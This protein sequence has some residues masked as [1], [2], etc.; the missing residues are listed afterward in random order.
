MRILLLTQWFEPEPT[1]K[2]MVFAREL[3]ARG[4]SVQVL[5]GFPNYPGGR[6]YPGYKVRPWLREQREGV[7]IVRVALY[8][9]HDRNALGRAANYLSFAASAAFLGAFLVAKPDVVYVYH[10][11]A[12]VGLAALAISLFRGA[13]FVLDIQDLWPDS[14]ASSGMLA[15]PAAI[16]LLASWCRLLYR[17]AAKIVVLSD[18]FRGRLIERGVPPSKIE[19]IR[20][21]C[22]EASMRQ[23]PA[24]EPEL[25]AGFNVVF[26]GAMG[27]MQGLD[28]VLDASKICAAD[29][30]EA[31]FVFVGGGIERDRL[32]RRAHAEGLA[33]VLFLPRRP[34]ER[35]GALFAQ[36]DVLL[37][38]LKDDPLFRITIP[39]KMQAYM[40]AGKTILMAVAGEAA[41][42]VAEAEAGVTCE[43]DN[44][45]QIA[46][47]VASLARMPKE[48]LARL[49]ANGARYYADNMSLAIGAAR[50]DRIFR[51]VAAVSGTPAGPYAAFGKRLFDL[52]A[53]T[54]AAVL[55]SP[56]LALA[57]GSIKASSSGPVLFRQ[58][59]IG[60]G[61]RPF[62]LLKFRTMTHRHRVPDRQTFW[63]DPE[64]TSVGKWLRRFKLDEL[65]QLLNVIRGEMS[66]VGPRPC[67]PDLLNTID[68]AGR[69]RF[70]VRPGL[71][72]LA[73][74][75][76]NVYIS[77]E[78]RWR[79]DADY[80]RR[81][82]FSLDLRILIR[83]VAVVL[84]GE[85]RFAR[86]TG[87]PREPE[88][89]G[90]K[91]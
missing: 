87:P 48:E 72:G 19:V 70:L 60:L 20:N 83:T 13:P 88:A 67:L 75:N 1:F 46:A 40:V 65:P 63:D 34:P 21:W 37:V 26:A 16:S 76:G 41:Q 50:F 53:G 7:S 89:R 39:S 6:L 77:W 91:L 56:V 80:V 15:V 49:G 68:E 31:R 74:V 35:M 58:T 85:H 38:H 61:E 84:L 3:A 59:R 18:G 62:S 4:H 55:L 11:P 33:N 86:Q 54:L 57:A 36:A 66:L 32:A 30:P 12:T 69:E 10:P 81:L 9:S 23:V 47:A 51:S 42:L 71:T 90:P 64:T 82:S 28:S 78:E 44:P 52:L 25:G 17:R 2:G 45:E 27:L 29:T 8:P 24:P 43:P 73:Q 79:F 22:D 14:V 5:T